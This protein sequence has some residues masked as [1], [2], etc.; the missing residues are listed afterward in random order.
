MAPFLPI[1]PSRYFTPDDLTRGASWLR[2]SNLADGL[3]L[4]ID[5]S[6]LL[7][8]TFSEPGRRLWERCAVWTATK[9]DGPLDRVLGPDWRTGALFLALVA[10]LRNAVAFP[11]TFAHDYFGAHALG[12]SSETLSSFLGDEALSWSM[13]IVLNGVLGGTLGGVRRLWPRRWWLVIG[14][15]ASV[16]LVGDAVV[17]PLWANVDYKVRPLAPGPLRRRLEALLS[18]FHT[19]AGEIVVIDASRYGTSA[20][21]SVT[22][23]GPTRRLV[24]TDTLLKFG[25]EAVVGA[26]AHEI[27]HRRDERLPARLA[28][29][30]VALL[31]FLWLV[32]RACRVAQRRGALG[33]AQCLPFVRA[34]SLVLLVVATPIRSVFARDEER[35]ADAVEL[36]HRRDYDAY[37]SEQVALVRANALDPSPPA[38]V[39]VLLDH[40]SPA[41]R[42]GRALWYK[43]HMAGG[44]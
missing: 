42:I 29:S 35:E 18:E 17:E 32:E 44:R 31:A 21:A 36:S 39:N 12:L 23:F 20:N 9:S 2:W 4:V 43:E 10:L 28:W 27:G 16:A 13:S 24:L 33:T 25:D 3:A 11:V 6:I 8:A 22:G 34:I 30:A 15:A 7:F 40:P 41:E 1:E 37:V 26:V 5:L 14:L 38:S 19:S